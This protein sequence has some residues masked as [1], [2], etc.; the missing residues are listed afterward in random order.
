MCR[1]HENSNDPIITEPYFLSDE[2]FAALSDM[3]KES[4]NL[5]EITDNEIIE[6]HW[7]I[8]CIYTNRDDGCAYKCININV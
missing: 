4:S 3:R 8:L 6:T 2:D 7:K 5:P 1:N